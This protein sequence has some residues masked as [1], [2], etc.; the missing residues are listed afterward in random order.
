[1]VAAWLCFYI[2]EDDYL[3][4]NSGPQRSG[5]SDALYTWMDQE[6]LELYV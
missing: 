4:L 2:D 6:Q 3:E 1:M 5:L